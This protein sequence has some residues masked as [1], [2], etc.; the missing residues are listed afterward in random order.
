MR[1]EITVH[2]YTTLAYVEFLSDV[3]IDFVVIEL[4]I[5]NM[6]VLQVQAWIIYELTCCWQRCIVLETSVLVSRAL[7]RTQWH[8]FW[9]SELKPRSRYVRSWFLSRRSVLN[10]FNIN[11]LH[12][13]KHTN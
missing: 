11:S 7:I 13:G 4:S 6:Q 2:E 3:I 8:R 12:G 1:V 10:I 5:Y 9:S